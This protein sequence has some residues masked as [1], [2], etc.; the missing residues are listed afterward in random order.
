MEIN[1]IKESIN[2]IF[3]KINNPKNADKLEKLMERY[4]YLL[5]CYDVLENQEI[6]KKDEQFTIRRI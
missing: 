4:Y 5:N 2:K 3:I 1:K 6:L